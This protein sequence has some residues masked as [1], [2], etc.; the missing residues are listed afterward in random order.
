MN[1]PVDI[2][3]LTIKILNSLDD[4]YRELANAIQAHESPVTFEELYENL[5]N[6]EAHLAAKKDAPAPFLT[7]AHSIARTPL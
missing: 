4:S 2:K 1:A 7:S 5:I 6:Y 3:D